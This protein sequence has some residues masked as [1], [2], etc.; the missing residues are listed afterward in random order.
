MIVGTAGHIDHGKSTRVPALTG[1]VFRVVRDLYYS[2]AAIDA[3]AAQARALHD[4]SAA[5]ITAAAFRDR[6]L[7]RPDT[8]L[9]RG[10]AATPP[11]R[12]RG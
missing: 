9:F 5:G 12:H 10:T 2:A 11:G 6:H 1:R 4:A 7:L 8:D 3:P